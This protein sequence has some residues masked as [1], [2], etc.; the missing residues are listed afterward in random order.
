MIKLLN[1]FFNND[2]KIE[3]KKKNQINYT[4]TSPFI[5]G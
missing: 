4:E 5:C 3:F 2:A 1:S